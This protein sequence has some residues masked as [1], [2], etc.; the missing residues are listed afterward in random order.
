MP[1]RAVR[2]SARPRWR[3][4]GG[5]QRRALPRAI[6]APPPLIVRFTP[7]G[8]VL[9]ASFLSLL[10]LPAALGV[11]PPAGLLMMIA[12][13]MQRSDPWPAW[14][15][16]LLGLADDLIAGRPLGLMAFCYAFVMLVAGL[17][18]RR[19]EWRGWIL[20]WAMAALLIA[21]ALWLQWQVAAWMGAAVSPTTLGAAILFAWLGFPAAARLVMALDRWRLRRRD[22]VRGAA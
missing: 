22:F 2:S 15:A 16:A 17:V 7:A 14:R 18:D 5:G 3:S 9:G 11:W 4:A 6:L 1:R 21:S 12:W 8:S 10:P 19:T 13:R 20:S